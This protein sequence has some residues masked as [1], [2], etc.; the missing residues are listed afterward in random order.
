[1]VRFY[2]PKCNKV[3]R[4]RKRVLS[5][6]EYEHRTASGVPVKL[7]VVDCFRHVNERSK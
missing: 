6:T 3:R 2:C 1:M 7:P 4:T 5:V